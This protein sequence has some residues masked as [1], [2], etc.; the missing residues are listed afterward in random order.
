MTKSKPTVVSA[1]F[2]LVAVAAIALSLYFATA[3]S[4]AS[5]S[6]TPAYGGPPAAIL[7]EPRA[8]EEIWEEE[9]WDERNSEEGEAELPEEES[10]ESAPP[11]ECN[12]YATS[13]RIVA[14]DRNDSVHLTVGYEAGEATNVKVEYWLKGGRG[15]FQLK[16]LRRH[17]STGGTIQGSELLSTP[18]MAKVRMARVFVVHLDIP[19]LSQYCKR[20]STLRLTAKRENGNRTTWSEPAVGTR[21]VG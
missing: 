15:S 10:E 21:P 13:A 19:G 11:E 8:E 2:G 7:N 18:E 17:M 14:S 16:P 4:I 6:A 20:Y 5:A 3:S 12:L 9:G 1:R